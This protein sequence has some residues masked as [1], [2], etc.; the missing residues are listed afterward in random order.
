MNLVLKG[1]YWKTTTFSLDWI[2]TVQ[3]DGQG[4]DRLSGTHRPP[5]TP[6]TQKKQAN[7]LYCDQNFFERG[8]KHETKVYNL[9][10]CHPA[11]QTLQQTD[12]LTYRL[13]QAML[14]EK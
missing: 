7:V 13:N 1:V 5:P 8:K 2:V 9:L 4:E 10:L 12:I 14:S 11:S 3:S 6:E